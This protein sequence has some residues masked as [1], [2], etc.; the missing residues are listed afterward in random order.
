MNVR[1]L[2]DTD[3]AIHFLNANRAIV[4]RLDELKDEGLAL[5]VVSL[6]ERFE[7]VYGSTDPLQNERRLG[8]FLRGLD[9]MGVDVETCQVFGREG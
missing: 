2:V 4:E 7:G 6:A 1:Y 5:S 9:V 8:E 3:W